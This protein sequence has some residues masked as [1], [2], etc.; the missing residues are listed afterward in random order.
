MVTHPGQLLDHGGDSIQ[1]PQLTGEPVGGGA[2]EQD[3]FDLTELAVR[4]PWCR[5]GRPRLRRGIG[6]ASLPVA[7]ALAG[8]AELA[9]DLGAPEAGGKQFGSA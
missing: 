7:D 8:D 1:R 9:G 3:V 4:Q 2:L 5:S 6:A